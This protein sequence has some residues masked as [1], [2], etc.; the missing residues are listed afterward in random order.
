M[1]NKFD[2][3]FKTLLICFVGW[4]LPN[5]IWA[6]ANEGDPSIVAT[7]SCGE[8]VA[9]TI[10]SDMSM[11]IS[12]TGEMMDYMGD[13]PHID[14]TYYQK[15]ESVVIE[16]GV[17]SIGEF[18]F[19][20]FIHL[21]SMSIANSVTKIGN[22]AFYECTSLTSLDIPNGVIEIGNGVFYGCAELTSIVIPD[23]VKVISPVLFFNC[24]GLTSVTIP[25]GVTEIGDAAFECCSSLTSVLIPGSVTSIG[26]A[27]FELCS[28]LTSITVENETPVAIGTTTFNGVDKSACILH[29]PAGTKSAYE[30]AEVWNEFENIEEMEEPNTD[31]SALDNAIYVEQVEGRIGGTMDIPVLLKNAYGVR[32]FQF[33]LEL[34]MGTTINSWAMVMNRMP[35]GA[36]LNDAIST[37]KIE[38]NKIAVAFS[39]NYGSETFTGNDGEIAT[40]N[41]T[42]GEEMD[43]GTYPIYF[44]ACDVTTTG[45]TDEDLSDIKAALVLEDY[46]L[47]DANSDGKV[48]IGDATT[49]LNYIVGA[50][51]DNFNMK[52]ADANCDGKIRIGDATTI[53]NIIINQ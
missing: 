46:I 29:V 47:G 40:V 36:T 3:S 17:T 13:I 42:F 33:T 9:Y 24:T 51:S 31:I 23:G 2:Y 38:G 11:V 8:S 39:L 30:N 21:T 35:E 20:D 14:A 16:E 1:N 7:G 4:L 26:D 43:A 44:T 27:A 19:Y 45:G 10:Y 6:Q 12:G 49:V 5:S 32:G 48:R 34:P 53:L 41:V 15:I 18:A 50:V 25:N 52:A 22:A 37:Q 28:S